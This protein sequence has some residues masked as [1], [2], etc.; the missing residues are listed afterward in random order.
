MPSRKRKAGLPD[1]GPGPCG[2]THDAACRASTS[3]P[4]LY[5][6][7]SAAFDGCEMCV[8]KALETGDVGVDERSDVSGY[9]ALSWALWGQKQGRYTVEVQ[10]LL[11]EHGAEVPGCKEWVGT[12][13]AAIAAADS[14]TDGSGPWF[15]LPAPRRSGPYAGAP[16]CSLGRNCDVDYD[17]MY[18]F[19][20]SAFT[21]C[22]RHVRYYVEV[23]KVDV[24]ACLPS[25][26][27][28]PLAWAMVGQAFFRHSTQEV[29]KYLVARGAE[30]CAVESL[31]FVRARSD[32]PWLPY[33][34]GPKSL[35]SAAGDVNSGVVPECDGVVSHQVLL[36]QH[37]W[38]SRLCG[39]V[40]GAA[41][42]G[43]KEWVGA[44]NTARVAAGSG[45][46]ESGPWS[47]L[48]APRR[49]GPYDC[50][51]SCS[52]GRKYGVDYDK[53]YAFVASAFTGCLGHVRHYV[54]V[55]K[56]DVDACFSPAWGT[57]LAWAMVGQAFF[58]HSTQEVQKYLVARGAEG[59]AVGKLLLARARSQ[60]P[61]LPDILEPPPLA[62]AAGDVNSG[63]VPGCAGLVSHQVS[64]IQQIWH[65]RLCG[66][67]PAGERPRQTSSRQLMSERKQVGGRS[68]RRH[69]MRRVGT[70]TWTP[71]T[72]RP[73]DASRDIVGLDVCTSCGRGCGNT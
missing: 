41:S 10:K 72:R 68:G 39:T 6:F 45:T 73:R 60:K 71:G 64:L 70:V 9:T 25:A 24:D 32:E 58:R 66:I 69:G 12:H 4:L 44:H 15:R 2:R 34:L 20:A 40:P 46:D 38:P 19:V 18:D 42:P 63:V 8:R 52:T 23:E 22:L 11:R 49:S 51:T 55:E 7:F 3:R 31:V 57:P 67:V 53:M 21:G 5:S 47:R 17:K 62:F 27:G 14:G 35:S 59:C 48:P 54:E 50:A 61:W 65:P 1:L 26:W 43:H 28:S 29:Q 56:M 37:I 33:A 30:E 36:I 13:Y 16:L